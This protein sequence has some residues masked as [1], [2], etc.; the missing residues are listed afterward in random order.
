MN[1]LKANPIPPPGTTSYAYNTEI[2]PKSSVEARMVHPLAQPFELHLV[3][4]SWPYGLRVDE[5]KKRWAR[6]DITDA[7]PSFLDLLTKPI[8]M[9]DMLA[10]LE[11]TWAEIRSS[12]VTQSR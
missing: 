3:H 8:E 6:S 12:N 10:V 2:I 9:K 4:L 5:H 1:I 7:L 11:P